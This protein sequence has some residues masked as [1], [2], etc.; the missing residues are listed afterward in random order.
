[1]G[2]DLRLTGSLR[3]QTDNPEAPPGFELNNPWKVRRLSK[4]CLRGVTD[5]EPRWS[6]GFIRICILF[7]VKYI[8]STQSKTCIIC[9]VVAIWTRQIIFVSADIF[10]VARLDEKPRN[11]PNA[12]LNCQVDKILPRSCLASPCSQK[13]GR[14]VGQLPR[15]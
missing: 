10:R 2:R 7:L 1:M 14:E 3:G 6:D 15:R 9:K 4:V 5:V 13:R 12:S 11:V 8:P